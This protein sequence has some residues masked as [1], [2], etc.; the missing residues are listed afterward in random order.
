MH[1][2][3]ASC[4]LVFVIDDDPLIRE[5]LAAL[6]GDGEHERAGCRAAVPRQ[7]LRLQ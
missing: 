4:L 3:Q 1:E 7:I 5:A 6:S 2:P